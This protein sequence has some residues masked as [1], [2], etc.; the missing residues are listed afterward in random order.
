[1]TQNKL[2]VFDLVPHV[3]AGKVHLG[4]SRSEVR[5]LLGAPVMS[6]QKV[7][8]AVLTDRYFADLQVAYDR[9]DRAEYIE[10]NGPGDVDAVFHG[11]SLLFLPADEVLDWMKRFAEY[12]PDDPEPGYSYVYPDL[13]MS[14]WRPVL[15]ENPE[16]DDGRFFQSVGIARTGYFAKSGASKN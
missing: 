14:V 15:P 12:D 10:L 13:D 1:M 3:G 16:D 6:Y 11:R 4:M 5:R 9:Q 2:T 8:D 7:P